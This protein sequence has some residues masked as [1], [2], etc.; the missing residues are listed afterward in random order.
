MIA[1]IDVA[2]GGRAAEDLFMGNDKI[3]TGCS[4][5]LQ[6]ATEIAYQYVKYLG[7][8]EDLTLISANDKI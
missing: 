4:N 3:T 6:K 8:N 7:M 2:M 5:D 1:F